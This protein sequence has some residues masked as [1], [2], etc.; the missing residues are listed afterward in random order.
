[1]GPLLIYGDL[2]SLGARDDC[3]WEVVDVVGRCQDVYVVSRWTV[4]PVLSS[5]VS[6]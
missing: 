6:R 3:Q 5:Q 1:M 4:L 2:D